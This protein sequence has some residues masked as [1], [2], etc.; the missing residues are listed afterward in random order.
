MS[1]KMN[2]IENTNCFLIEVPMRHVLD[3]FNLKCMFF[4]L[5]NFVLFLI[6]KRMEK[7]F[8]EN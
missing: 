4:L 6:C 3:G 5:R 8:V 1:Q 7:V 2:S